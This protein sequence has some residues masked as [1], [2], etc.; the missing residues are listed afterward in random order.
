MTLAVRES[1]Q[2]IVACGERKNYE[3]KDCF[4]FDW[5][6]WE[7]LPP[8]QED[9]QPSLITTKSFSLDSGVWVG[10]NSSSGEMVNEL[11][12][13]AEGQWTS[14]PVGSPYEDN[15][16]QEPCVSPQNK[17]HIFFSGGFLNGDD[18]DITTDTW[19]LDTVNLVWTPST[20]MMAPRWLHGCVLTVKFSKQED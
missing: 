7:P 4:V 20:P 1:D 10:G 3:N 17:T 19:I 6:T 18:K 2:N 11:L 13:A 16:Y 5:N 15:Y 9:H 14:L 8:L 12:L